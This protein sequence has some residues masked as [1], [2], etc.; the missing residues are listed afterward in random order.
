MVFGTVVV[1]VVVLGAAAVVKPW[2]LEYAV[3]R[4]P[5]LALTRQK[6]VVE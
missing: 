1:V 2:T 4:P 6:Y 3:V 5:S